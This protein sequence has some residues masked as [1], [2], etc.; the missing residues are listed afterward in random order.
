[1]YDPLLHCREPEHDSKCSL[2]HLYRPVI[3]FLLSKGFLRGTLAG[4]PAL[5]NLDLTQSLADRKR[6]GRPKKTSPREDRAIKFNSLQDR[7]LTASTMAKNLVPKIVKNQ[8]AKI[9]YRSI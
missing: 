4:S 5:I 7:F 3:F 6:S 2:A 1:M 8:N 9:N